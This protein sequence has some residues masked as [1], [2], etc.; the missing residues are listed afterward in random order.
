LGG[1]VEF[2]LI[3]RAASA[4]QRAWLGRGGTLSEVEQMRAMARRPDGTRRSLIELKAVDGLYPLYGEVALTPEQGLAA[5]LE[6]RDGSWG[7][8]VDPTI[9][10]RLGLALGDSMRI[11]EADFTIR[12]TLKREPDLGGNM[13]IFGPRV[14]VASGGL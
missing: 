7:A 6:R 5:A 9:L 12:A 13:L 10:T 3:N 11:G 4:E 14:M 1:D 8:V 2:H